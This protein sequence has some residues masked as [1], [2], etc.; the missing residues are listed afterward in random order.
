MSNTFKHISSLFSHF[1]KRR[2]IQ[3]KLTLFFGILNSLVESISVASIY[4]L[5]TVITNQDKLWDIYFFSN[6]LL[7]LGLDKSDD[8]VIPVIII[9]I[10]VVILATL[11]RIIN[12]YLI[13]KVTALLGTDLSLKAFKNS[14]FQTYQTHLSISSSKSISQIVYRVNR[15]V[16]VLNA[17]MLGFSSLI[18]NIFLIILM[19]IFNFKLTIILL[20]VFIL[21]YLILSKLVKKRLTNNSKIIDSNS[22]KQIKMMQDSFGSIKELILNANHSFFINAHKEF[23][24]PMRIKIAEN[25][26]LGIFPRFYLEN[27]GLIFLSLISYY[28]FIEY[29]NFEV[30]I[31]T[32]GPLALAFQKMLPSF[33]GLFKNWTYVQSN[34]ISVIEITKNLNKPISLKEY[35]WKMP[36]EFRNNIVFKDIFFKYNYE[37]K[38]VIKDFNLVINKGERLGIKG[39]TGS[40]KTTFINILM[41]LLQPTNGDLLVDDE[42]IFA[43][44][45]IKYLSAWRQNISHVPQNIFLLDTSILENIAFGF[46][47]KSINKERLIEV[48]KLAE[49]YEFIQSLPSGF[50][51]IVGERGIKLSGGQKQRIAI[52]RALYNQKKIIILDEATSALDRITEAK[53]MK[54]IY[55]LGREITIIIIAHRESTLE[56][57]DRCI[58]FN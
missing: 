4:P 37:D 17:L 36:L 48:A 22:E 47:E 12:S 15:T 1:S 5:L 58:D 9:F 50:N 45:R 10:L 51:T 46:K 35:S 8:L 32:I 13:T 42:N 33:Y 28:L 29:R 14:I 55:N 41:G 26:F 57:C 43:E 6:L 49:I 52:A 38:F 34:I 40:G 11:I 18:V 19:L 16:Q 54:S 25:T 20:S 27:L 44:D 24:L 31:L 30:I 39:K 7:L 56:K 2:L 3:V 21:N 53:F 23:D